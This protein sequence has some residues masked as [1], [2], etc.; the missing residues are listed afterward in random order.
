MLN[1]IIQNNGFKSVIKRSLRSQNNLSKIQMP[2][3]HFVAY[4]WT[5][6]KKLTTSTF[7][8]VANIYCNAYTA[9][10]DVVGLTYQL[11]HNSETNIDDE[12]HRSQTLTY[13]IN[14]DL[15]KVNC[16]KGRQ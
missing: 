4:L 14:L 9:T 11:T 15:V 10:E 13:D 5:Q 1:V 7:T 6:K 3:T 2:E 8:Y 16:K 12:L